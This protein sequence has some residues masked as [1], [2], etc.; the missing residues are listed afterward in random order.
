M[1][2]NAKIYT[3]NRIDIV[4]ETCTFALNAGMGIAALIGIWSLACLISGLAT[5]GFGGLLRGFWTA[6]TGS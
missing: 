5:N 2:A 6:V 4:R 1:R 3:E